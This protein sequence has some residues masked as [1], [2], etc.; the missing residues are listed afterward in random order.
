MSFQWAAAAILLSLASALVSLL[1]S[2][3]GAVLRRLALPLFGLAGGAA[4]VAGLLALSGQGVASI[5][6]PLG[7]PWLPWHWRLD[8]LNG[9]FLVILGLLGVAVGIYAPGYVRDFE[10][11]QDSIAALGA[12]S[13]LFQ[14]GMLLVLLADD[15]FAFMLAWELMSLSSYFLV[16]FHHENAANR[17]AAFL[18]LLIAHVGGLAILLAFAVLGAA[19][20]DW[21]FDAMRAAS[22]SPT[23]ASLAFALA[24]VGFGAKAGL[25]PLHAWLPEAHPVAPSHISALMSGVML[26]VAAY[27]FLRVLFDLIDQVQ[28][29]WG[30]VVVFVGSLTALFGV[31]AAMMQTNL[32]RLLAYSSAENL[33]VIFVAFGLAIIFLDR[34][35]PDLAALALI[36]GLY[37]SLN[38]ASFKGLLFFGAGAVLH[39]SHE[40]DLERMGGLL[41][42]M[43]WTG[44]FFLIGCLSIAPLPPFNG[45]ASEWMILQSALQ[46]WQLDG[47]LIRSLLPIAIAALALTGALVAATMVKAYGVAFLG[48]ARSRRARRARPVPMSMRLGQALLAGVCILL[49]LFPGQVVAML[50]AVPKLLF[51]DAPLAV[52][53]ASWAW[54]KPIAAHGASYSG[55]ALALGLVAAWGLLA[56]A[57]RRG[58][59]RRI[60]RQ[61]AWD[62]GFAVPNERMQYSATAFAQPVRRVFGGLFDIKEE[63]SCD[64]NGQ[65]R[66]QIRIQ[67]RFWNGLYMPVMAAVCRSSKAI[68]NL[69]SGSLRLYLGWT[70]STLLVLLW[71]IS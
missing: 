14:A 12:F 31:L 33:G 37:H 24:F 27:G 25:L 7:L 30:V 20:G 50:S 44:L 38:H 52:Y 54:L 5:E 21:S 49:G 2:R 60:R 59:V 13:G 43:P 22:L 65:Q 55:L 32:K 64:D 53:E 10:G 68:V 56:W 51:A 15:A 29:Q 63:L 6:L 39:S 18:Y 57:I 16:V 61:D 48:Q 41:R 28:W 69:Q 23:Q 46:V 26:K 45:F 1:A 9:V 47:G 3:N 11:G 58:P 62:C 8:A 34:Q 67:D 35:H 70:L 4:L 19:A 71:I 17:R 36:A 40:H 42:R 66:Y